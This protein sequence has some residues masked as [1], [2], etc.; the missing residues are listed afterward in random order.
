MSCK[1]EYQGKTIAASDAC[2]MTEGVMYF[3]P[4]SVNRDLLRPSDTRY[5]CVWKGDAGYHDM[6]IDGTILKDAAWYYDR[7]SEAAMELKDYFA[8]DQSQGIIIT[9]E[10]AKSIIR[11]WSTGY[12]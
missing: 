12:R 5:H 7:P 10:P 2:L 11:P 3:P 1:A 8:F 9:G 4:D 6:V